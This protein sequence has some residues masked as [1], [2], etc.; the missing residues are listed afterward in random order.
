MAL[1]GLTDSFLSL[2][3]GGGREGE[4]GVSLRYKDKVSCT[5]L[6][7]G[8]LSLSRLIE[9]SSEHDIKK[10]NYNLRRIKH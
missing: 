7:V 3:W 2:F 8:I 9:I 1:Q 6:G 5:L 4:E 10:N